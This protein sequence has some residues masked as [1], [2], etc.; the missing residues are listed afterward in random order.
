MKPRA[1]IVDRSWAWPA[2]A[3]VTWAS[4]WTLAWLVARATDSSLAGMAAGCLAA[5]GLAARAA[6]PARRALLATGFPASLALSGVA[7]GLPPWA[8]LFPLAALLMI[9]PVRAWRDAP[10]FPTAP[11]ALEGLAA[12]LSLPA[13]PRLLDAGCGLGHGLRALRREW[14]D[15]CLVGV[16][17]S[18]LLAA[19]CA[20]T[21]PRDRIRCADMWQ[22]AWQDYDLVYVFQRPESMAEAW[23]KACNDMRPGSWLVSL[24]FPVPGIRADVTRQP[25][26]GRPV[27]AYRIPPSAATRVALPEA[28]STQCRRDLVRVPAANPR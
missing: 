18:G 23:R 2:V 22:L 27:R 28:A 25:P 9:Y 7:A 5:C 3:I 12:R 10:V 24:D 17:R 14:A 4:A 16:E 6:T 8:W 13:T 1:N 21:R 26:G 11:D 19:L 20:V 15:A